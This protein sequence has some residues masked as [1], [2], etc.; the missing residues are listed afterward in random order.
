MNKIVWAIRLVTN[1]GTGEPLPI[2]DPTR[3]IIAGEFHFVTGGDSFPT[4]E[5]LTGDGIATMDDQ[6]WYAGFIIKDGLGNPV[7]QVDIVDG[8]SWGSINGWAF[9]LDNTNGDAEAFWVW[10]KAQGISFVNRAVTL[11]AFVQETI[12]GDW[13]SVQRWTGFVANDPFTATEFQVECDGS[14]PAQNT[15]LPQKVLTQA[16]FPG[17]DP[18]VE[19]TVMPI[20]L[21]YVERAVTIPANVSKQV[22]LAVAYAGEYSAVQ[23]QEFG[24]AV[25]AYCTPLGEQPYLVLYTKNIAFGENE[26]AQGYALKFVR[27]GNYTVNIVGNEKT[28]LGTDADTTQWGIASL[29]KVFLSEALDIASDPPTVTEDN[30]NWDYPEDE[31]Y[32]GK[33]LQVF[34]TLTVEG[35]VTGVTTNGNPNVSPYTMGWNS[36]ATGITTNVTFNHQLHVLYLRGLFEIGEDVYISDDPKFTYTM[37][38]AAALYVTNANGITHLVN[39]GSLGRNTDTAQTIFGLVDAV[40]GGNRLRFYRNSGHTQLIGH[41]GTYSAVGPQTIIP[42]DG[43]SPV[44]VWTGIQGTVEIASMRT[45][46]FSITFAG[47]DNGGSLQGI[48][49]ITN[50]PFSFG[51]LLTLPY[52]QVRDTTAEIQVINNRR[53]LLVSESPISEYYGAYENNVAVY[54]DGAYENITQVVS[55]FSVDAGP[56]VNGTLNTYRM[57]LIFIA[58]NRVAFGGDFPI[59][60]PVTPQ[61]LSASRYQGQVAANPVV[62]VDTNYSVGALTDGNRATYVTFAGVYPANGGLSDRVSIS[63]RVF[64]PDNFLTERFEKLYLCFDASV[65]SDSPYRILYGAAYGTLQGLPLR[66]RNSTQF[67][68]AADSFASALQNYLPNEYYKTPALANGEA[69]NFGTLYRTGTGDIYAVAPKLVLPVTLF[70]GGAIAYGYSDLSLYFLNIGVNSTLTVKMKEVGIVGQKTANI[71]NNSIYSR[72]VGE[73]TLDGST[74]TNIAVAFGWFMEKMGLVSLWSDAQSNLGLVS[75]RFP[76]GLQMTEGRS[77]KE[78]LTEMTRQA[79]FCVY[80]DRKGQMTAKNWLAQSSFVDVSFDDDGGD[81]N[82]GSFSL[83]KSNYRRLWNTFDFQYHYDAGS[84]RFARRLSIRK[85]D[86]A[87]FPQVYESTNPSDD[88]AVTFTSITA[89]YEGGEWVAYVQSPSSDFQVGDIFSFYGGAAGISVFFA[90]VTSVVPGVGFYTYRM[91]MEQN[92]AG[93]AGTVDTMGTWLKQGSSTAAWTEYVSGL[94]GTQ[95]WQP[96]KE[97]WEPCHASYLE[98]LSIQP[99]PSDLTTLSYFVDLA[100]FYG[101][102]GVNYFDFS[103]YNSAKNHV[104]YT[105]KQRDIYSYGIPMTLETLTRDLLDFGTVRDYVFTDDE[106]KAGWIFRIEDEIQTDTLNLKVMGIP[107]GEPFLGGNV[108]ESGDRAANIDEDGSQTDNVIESGDR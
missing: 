105:T 12:G 22:P 94:P 98:T 59:F 68:N 25:V 72:I 60:L 52:G 14:D 83:E 19:N 24:C 73:M 106:V 89:Q 40:S 51:A 29:T 2:T 75:D 49:S 82:T 20:A 103:A 39:R 8:G 36:R 54:L 74:T 65:E 55:D 80:L 71:S 87:A 5:L 92:F 96:A 11:Y 1:D 69:S 66:V 46:A 90:P 31:E 27:G 6:D 85:P 7:R 23:K 21:G 58:S 76:I 47:I 16:S 44:P 17:I 95:G 62:F 4:D 15:V 50:S 28:T 32:Q 26:M 88:A 48:V 107:G 64:V 70:P 18:G 45:G 102:P 53:V 30:F 13:V 38:S 97:L 86:A 77:A 84:G 104:D 43:V 81:I 79:W 108:I 101:N 67:P 42:D 10:A 9:R 93:A 56:G 57:P 35:I 100:K 41:T 3:G 91:L 34:A 63:M 37:D 78:W 33:G 61:I 99:A